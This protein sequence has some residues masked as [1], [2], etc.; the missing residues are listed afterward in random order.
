MSLLTADKDT[1]QCTAKS[2]KKRGQNQLEV[3][4]SITLFRLAENGQGYW[5]VQDYGIHRFQTLIHV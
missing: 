5:S 4:S 3:L 1:Q 2:S